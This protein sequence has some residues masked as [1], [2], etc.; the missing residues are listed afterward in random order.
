MRLD[1]K[2]KITECR[3]TCLCGLMPSSRPSP[4]GRGIVSK[5]LHYCSKCLRHAMNVAGIQTRHAHTSAGNQVDAELFAQTFNLCGAQPGVAKH[6]ALFKQIVEVMP[7]TAS[8][9]TL[10]NS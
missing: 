3:A 10:T 1:K 8:F 2:K 5:Y 7:R 4:K 6:P 9:S